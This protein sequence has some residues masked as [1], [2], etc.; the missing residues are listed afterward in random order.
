MRIIIFWGVC[1][2]SVRMAELQD[3][4]GKYEE[5]YNIKVNLVNNEGLVQIDTDM[6]NMEK[7]VVNIDILEDEDKIEYIYHEER[8]WGIYCKQIYRKPW[9]AS[10]CTK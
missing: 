4:L 1:G 3:I 8:K 6:I 7:A 10:G 2:V 9:M 5:K